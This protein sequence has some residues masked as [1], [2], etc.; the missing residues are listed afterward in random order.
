MR[1]GGHD[2]AVHLEGI[3]KQFGAVPVLRNVSW[4]V[5]QGQITGLLGLNGS[6]KTTLL[7]VL[8]GIVRPTS[9]CGWV[10][11]RDLL[12]DA[13]AIRERIGYVAERNNMPG[14]FTADRLERVGRAVFPT[15]DARAYDVA[16]SRFH[17][18]RDKRVYR[19]SQGQRMLTALAFALAHHAEVLL[20]DEPTNGLDP[21]VRRDFLTNLIEGSYDQGRTVI[22]SSHRLEEV[23]DIAQDI[24]VLHQGTLVE[25]GTLED[26][27]ERDQI[28]SLRVG[29]EMVDLDH[30]PGATRVVRSQQQAS[31]YVRG[32]DEQKIRDSLAQQGVTDWTHHAVSLEQLFQDR[33]SAHVE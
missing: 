3:Q 22:V 25:V 17:I 29:S 23:A 6:G 5:P 1:S 7:R 16:L 30:L 14:A 32:F 33:V 21:L 26:L 13:P 27:L 4:S 18:L 20:L 9:G 8:M 11:D 24:A 31:V 2:T 15:W 19:M 28:V 10:R 12:T